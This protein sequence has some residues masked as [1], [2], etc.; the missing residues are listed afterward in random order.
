MQLD[1]KKSIG[2]LLALATCS[3]LSSHQATAEESRWKFDTALL[4]YDEDERVTAVE[5]VFAASKTFADDSKISLKLT[6]DSLTGASHNGATISDQ[7]QT[8]TG[9]SG[10]SSYTIP[11]GEIPLDDTFK[12]SRGAVSVQW[13]GPFKDGRSWSAGANLSAEYDFNSFSLNGGM[14]Q[15]F[16][17]KNTTLNL[18]ISI[19]QDQISPVGDTPLEGSLYSD[20][21]KKGS[22]ED[23]TIVDLL[24]GVTQVISRNTLMQF[25]V[26]LSHSSGYMTDPYKIV[27]VLESADLPLDYVYESRPDTRDK[28][29][30]F[31][32]TKHHLETDVIDVAYRY[33]TD[34]WG[35]DSH[36]LDF[37]YRWQKEGFYIEPHLRFY[38]QTAAD[39][40]RTNLTGSPAPG[41][42]GSIN[43]D[44]LPSEVSAD[45]RLSE[46]DSTTIGIKLAFDMGKD[47]ELSFRLEKYSQSGDTDPADLDALIF[48]AG[49]S[50]YF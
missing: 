45:Y 46:L 22:D 30:F 25:N 13:T 40:Y 24:A 50:F 38:Q 36:T 23:K 44:A 29:S 28:V 9:P 21:I 3:L 47:S 17:K 12:D 1:R 14:A 27:S 48:Q 10:S 32:K 11:A 4:Y 5:P 19:E 7:P 6:L 16:N 39:F 15:E 35:I 31:W 42:P 26:G 2:S 8:F 43:I 41:I 20:Q 49:Y 33:M 18:G 34:D 37:H